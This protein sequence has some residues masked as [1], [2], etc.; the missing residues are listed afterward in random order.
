MFYNTCSGPLISVVY[1]FYHKKYLR[2]FARKWFYCYLCTKIKLQKVWQRSI[3]L[4][5]LLN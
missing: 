1:R 3:G 2:V 5:I 4:R